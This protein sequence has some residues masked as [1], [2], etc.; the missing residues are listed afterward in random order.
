[1]D[2]MTPENHILLERPEPFRL[3]KLWDIYIPITIAVVPASIFRFLGLVALLWAKPGAQ[4]S[5][6]VIA[7]MVAFQVIGMIA[8]GVVVL[9]RFDFAKQQLSLRTNGCPPIWRKLVLMLSMGFILI[10]DILAN[11]AAL[12]GCGPVVGFAIPPFLMYL[13]CIRVA[14]V[15]L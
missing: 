3:S 11:T 12:P 13:L 9:M 7:V 4:L 14:F 10:V 5:A 6:W 2:C 8:M 1:M 15:G